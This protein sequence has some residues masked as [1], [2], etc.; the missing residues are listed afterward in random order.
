[1]NEP[2]PGGRVLVVEDEYLTA[3]QIKN[4]L[5]DLGCETIG[6]V[7]DV[8]SAFALITQETPDAALLDIC[9]DVGP[10]FLLAGLLEQ[11]CIPFGFAT[12]YKGSVLPPRFAAVPR[13]LKPFGRQELARFLTEAVGL[14]EKV[15]LRSPS[16]RIRAEPASPPARLALDFAGRSRG[17]R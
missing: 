4:M 11:R 12:G 13:L 8:A 6:P 17:R 9:L 16:G 14:D 5:R 3:I 2:R 10:C 15:P 7:G 1:M